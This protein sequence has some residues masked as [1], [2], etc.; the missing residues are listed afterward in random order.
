MKLIESV[1]SCQS[2]HEQ[3]VALHSAPIVILTCRLALSI[4]QSL[5]VEFHDLSPTT[6][7]YTKAVARSVA[8]NRVYA[9][10]VDDQLYS[11]FYYTN[12]VWDMIS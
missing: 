12:L 4:Y 10:D 7:R 5:G 11:P 6:Q 8:K 2:T 9:F 1:T 3:R